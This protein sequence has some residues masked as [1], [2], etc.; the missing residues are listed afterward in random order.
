MR[1]AGVATVVGV[2]MQAIPLGT[3]GGPRWNRAADGTV[4]HGIATAVVVDDAVYLIDA[5]HGAG[6]QLLRAGYEV[7]ALA[8]VFITH[9]HS[10]HVVELP[11]LALLGPWA[12]GPA[13]ERPIPVYGPGDRGK[14]PP[15]TPLADR[16][17][18]VIAPE[19]PTPGITGLF[20]HLERAFAADL[21]DRIRDTLKPRPTAYFGPVDI[22]IPVPVD[23]DADDPP[24]MEPFVVHRDD[25]VTVSAI[26]VKHPP[27]APALAFRVDAAGGSVVVSGDT[28]PTDNLV[29]LAQGADL[30]LHEALDFDGILA[31]RPPLET[32]SAAEQ[33]AFAHHRKAHT[34]PRD[35]VALAERAGVRRLALHHLAPATSPAA[36]W[37]EAA[38]PFDGELLVPADLDVIPIG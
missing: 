28:A 14:L 34:S 15:L 5:G 9:L 6:S 27:M 35:A 32:W 3:A 4:P 20:D 16:E 26:L 38:G 36:R 33:A 24:V 37:I 7:A 11:S 2:S 8:G 22:E 12:I 21:N 23:P 29:R 18:D 17:P 25:R 13:P 10:D 31:A 1:V 30:L 19:D